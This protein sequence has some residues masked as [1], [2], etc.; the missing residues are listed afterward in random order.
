MHQHL[1][2]LGSRELPHSKP[3]TLNPKPY[4]PTPKGT[5]KGSL[6]RPAARMGRAPPWAMG[7]SRVGMDIRSLGLGVWGLGLK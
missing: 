2:I 3:T 4:D 1:T 7:R 5:K 6:R